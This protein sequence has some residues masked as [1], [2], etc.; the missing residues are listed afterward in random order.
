MSNVFILRTDED[1]MR[2]YAFL[3]SNWKAMAEMKRPLQIIAAEHKTNRSLAQQ[4]FMWKAVLEPIEQQAMVA[5]TRYAAAAWHEFGKEKL[6][7]ETNAKGM[8]KWIYL[9]TGGRRLGYG[10]TDLNVAEMTE[11]L[12]ELQAYAATELGV[13]FPANQREYA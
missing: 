13:H 7:P 11:Y 2:L 9:P 6:L 3:R 10:T 4:S 5:G 1:C 12:E 8:P